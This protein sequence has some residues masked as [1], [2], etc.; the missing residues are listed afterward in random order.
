[1]S[2]GPKLK[3]GLFDPHGD[4]FDLGKRWEKWLERFE[5]DLK[6]NGVDSSLP[7]NSEKSQMALL[8]Y[9]GPEVEDIHDSLPTPVKPE[10]LDDENWTEYRKSK[11]KLNVYFL[12]QRSNDFALFELMRIKPV[13]D[14]RTRNYAARLRRAAEKCNFESWSSSKMIKCLIISNMQD[15][16]LRLSCLQREMSLDALLDKAEKKEDA[17]MMS[18]MMQNEE[19]V[20]EIKRRDNGT[21]KQPDDGEEC[22]KCGYS[23]HVDDLKCPAVSRTCNYC[24]EIGHF[25]K[26]CSKRSVNA[27]TEDH[28]EMRDS[29]DTDSDYDLVAS[30]K[31]AGI[32][33][34]KQKLL[35]V[36][37]NGL[38]QL[39][40]ADTGATRDIMSHLQFKDYERRLGHKIWL[41]PVQTRLYAF[42]S[43]KSLNLVGQ[44]NAALR[45][46]AKSIMTSIIV[47]KEP[48]DYP[49]LSQST[50]ENLSLVRYNR[51]FIVKS[52]NRV[53]DASSVLPSRAK[54]Q[55]FRGTPSQVNQDCQFKCDRYS[56]NRVNWRIFR[57]TST[58]Y[59]NDWDPSSYWRVRH[60]EESRSDEP[61]IRRGNLRV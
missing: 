5:R 37:M 32:Q 21:E 10:G 49:V 34:K 15:E 35:K 39:W 57:N 55:I 27:I 7:V 24:K 30:I 52:Q 33:R 19:H 47:T 2:R 60:K 58:R 16:Q 38:S 14:E 50:L 36:K 6:Y 29:T 45:A 41:S 26:V 42:G 54:Q 23:K 13:T 28:R 53:K 31:N 17:T 8:I 61:W 40:E 4:R 20:R 56:S 18:K 12:P 22:G 11:E 46:G 59:E 3:I 1:M 43:K 44:F 48:C 9:A 25:A 51:R